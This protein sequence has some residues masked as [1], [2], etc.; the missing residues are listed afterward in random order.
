MAGGGR[1]GTG[2]GARQRSH[3]GEDGRPLRK[4]RKPSGMPYSKRK[5]SRGEQWK[6]RWLTVPTWL[7][8]QPVQR[9]ESTRPALK[10]RSAGQRP[11]AEEQ[12]SMPMLAGDQVDEVFF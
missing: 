12:R 11:P 8:K 3:R 4:S 6:M 10:R 5:G 9:R 1:R 7:P 2:L